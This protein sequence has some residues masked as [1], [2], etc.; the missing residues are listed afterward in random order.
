MLLTDGRYIPTPLQP[1]GALAAPGLSTSNHCRLC[2]STPRYI[3]ALRMDI[4]TLGKMAWL[5][6]SQL[7]LSWDFWS[8]SAEENHNPAVD[9]E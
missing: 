8:R 4:E 9:N 2:E 6:Q 7:T 5:H 1:C 3:Y